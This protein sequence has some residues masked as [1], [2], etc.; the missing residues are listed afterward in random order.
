[1]PS[2]VAYTDYVTPQGQTTKIHTECLSGGLYRGVVSAAN[3]RE[4]GRTD[5]FEAEDD[6][7]QGAMALADRISKRRSPRG[8]IGEK[9]RRK[10]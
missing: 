10:T 1:M 6:A 8:S 3:Y 2:L 5:S 4:L 7:I 9:R